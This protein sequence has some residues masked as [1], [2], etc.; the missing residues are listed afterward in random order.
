MRLSPT[1]KPLL[2]SPKPTC[3]KPKAHTSKRRSLPALRAFDLQQV[4]QAGVWAGLAAA[5]KK[6]WEAHLRH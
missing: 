4:E 1:C 2:N 3:I 6:P 5:G